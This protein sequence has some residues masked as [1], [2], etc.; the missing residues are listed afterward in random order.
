MSW[1]NAAGGDGGWYDGPAE[2]GTASH[3]DGRNDFSYSNDARNH[4]AHDTSS[5]NNVNDDGACYNCGEPGHMKSECPNPRTGAQN[6]GQCYRCG[7][8]GHNKAECPNPAVA[9]EFT[10]TCRLCEETGHRA[11]DCPSASPKVC[12]NCEQEGHAVLECQNPRKLHR[13]EIPD[14]MPDVSWKELEAACS[15][16]DLEDI[17]I[18]VSKY[19]KALPATTY[20]ELEMGFRNQDL[21]LYLIALKRE[22]TETLTLMDLQGK[23]DRE[24]CISYRTSDKP[25]RPKEAEGWPTPEENRERLKNAGE[26]VDRLVP[27]CSNCDKLGHIAKSCSEER[28]ENTERVVVKCYNCDGQGHRVRDCPNPR[29]DRFACRNCKQSGHTSKECPEPRSAEGVECKKCGETGHFARDCPTGGGGGDTACRNCGQE[30]HRAKDCTEPR[31]VTCRN[32]D[33]VGHVSKECPKP[34]D[35]SR[36]KCSNCKKMGHTKVRC[37]EPLVDEDAADNGHNGVDA[38]TLED[39]A[40]AGGDDS[41][42]SSAPLPA[43]DDDNN[44]E[45][46][47]SEW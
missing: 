29:P 26:P 42:G 43:T 8:S 5:G 33:E 7:E 23:L 6:S 32:C 38:L 20:N 37:K 34:R 2:Q 11:A 16:G 1:D 31:V 35:Y 14:V 12:K 18:A 17:K 45:T 44:F 40:P 27:K 24:W 3:H 36:V 25:K 19:V 9:R 46:G 22:I 30:G 39:S 4:S 13:S 10:G 21:K 47:T 28:V 15:E 41:W